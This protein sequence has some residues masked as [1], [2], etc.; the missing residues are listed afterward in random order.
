LINHFIREPPRSNLT[1]YQT[2]NNHVSQSKEELIQELENARGK[3]AQLEAALDAKN[4]TSIKSRSPLSRFD[5]HFQSIID[6]S[7]VPYALNDDEQNIVYLNPAFTRTFGYDLSD[8]PTL[9]DWWPKAYPDENYRQWVSETW[10]LHLN[11]AIETGSDFEPIE[12]EI[13]CKDGSTRYVIASAASITES[14]QHIHQVT[15]FDVTESHQTKSELE[16]ALS[17]LDNVINSTP[18]LIFVKNTQLQTI[19]CNNAYAI[20]VGKSRE[21][22]YGKTDIE[23]GWNPELV[24]GNKE[25]GIR[26]FIQDDN[27]ALSGS[28]VYNPNDPANINGEIRIFDTRKLPLRNSEGDIIGMLGVARDITD[29][30]KATDALQQANTELTAILK[31]I[32]DL[33]FELDE[34][35]RY[36]NIWASDEQLLIDQK[37]LLLGKLVKDMLPESAAA[38]IHKSLDIASKEG[39]SQGQIIHLELPDG[40][41]WFELSTSLK[42]SNDKL[43]HFI[44]LSREITER[45]NTEQQLRRTQKMDALGKLTGGIAHDY[46]NMLGVVIGYAELLEGELRDQ[47]QLLNYI[48]QIQHAGERSA[49]LTQKLLAFSRQKLSDAEQLDIN[50]LL[51]SEQ[52]MLEKILTVRIRLTLDLSE[53]LWPVWLDASDME[54]AILNMSINAMHAIK[55]NG[56]LTIQTR[57][58]TIDQNEA[59]ALNLTPGNYVMVS[60]TDS[61]SGMN[62]AT[63]EKIFEPFFST[64]GDRGT[65]L[66]LSQVYGFVHGSG[67]TINVSSKPDQG[68]QFS[69]YFPRYLES[70]NNKIITEEK[71]AI[72]F[73]GH[74][75]ILVVDDEPALL[76][77][78]CELLGHDNF[79]LFTAENAKEALEILK[80][81]TINLLISD[82]I[83]P[84][85]DGYQLAAIVKEKYPTVKIQLVSGYY[86]ERN[87][88]FID[89]DLKIA[90]LAKPFSS[91]VLL[92]RVHDLMKE[93]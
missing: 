85:M 45:I 72:I 35:G 41:H 93:E 87:P 37:S 91:Q 70:A 21:E 30:N 66:G 43:K 6:L 71:A 8:I 63:T 11:K 4:S 32:P 20:A 26:G 24:H 17:M 75:S 16:K 55:D 40:E 46:N 25:K 5:I 73:S 48:Q 76:D 53:N 47:P 50:S 79:N 88:E 60:I 18:D 81:E 61:G 38:Q 31:A 1:R 86:D 67:G 12:L 82:V 42:P 36:L 14:Y 7:P 44:M 2:L 23:N 19:L 51:Q 22:M 27:E 74:Q 77:L 29:R 83:M 15:L 90:L 92:Q 9:K 64:K 69:L 52:H 10:S 57:N 28:H 68:T 78:T 84:E 59:R 3:V 33:L 13:R 62:M 65:G 89:K 49:K 39:V 54:D 34:D 58:Q 56:K 80:H